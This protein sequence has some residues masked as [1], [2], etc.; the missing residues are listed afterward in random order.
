MEL[1][2]SYEPLGTKN[3]CMPLITNF[4]RRSPPSSANAANSEDV[5]GYE[6]LTKKGPIVDGSANVTTS[7][8]NDP[9]AEHGYETVPALRGHATLSSSQNNATSSNS[10]ANNVVHLSVRKTNSDPRTPA[11]VTQLHSPNITQPHSRPR[12]AAASVVVIEPN[13]MAV[14]NNLETKTTTK[15]ADD[16]VQAHIFV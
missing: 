8:A 1:I 11:N 14:N 5:G 9:N 10:T 12:S 7:N 13:K 4:S 3:H 2:S 16:D 15:E 6:T